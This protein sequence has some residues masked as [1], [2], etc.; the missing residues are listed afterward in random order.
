MPLCLQVSSCDS[1]ALQLELPGDGI[2]SGDIFCRGQ[3]RSPRS[4]GELPP[5]HSSAPLHAPT[6]AHT[7][8]P[9]DFLQYYYYYL[10]ATGARPKWGAY[11]TIFQ[12]S[13]MFLGIAVVG[14]TLN[15]KWIQHKP[16][17]VT[18]GNI[19][20]ALLMYASYAALF[21]WFAVNRYCRRSSGNKAET[22]KDE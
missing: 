4:H 11:V 10:Q 21:I 1:A 7:L 6:N 3:L 2:L 14:A 8:L 19:I 9:F 15:Y 17:D 18:E 22:S 16:C 5:A 12:I 13:Q 20:A